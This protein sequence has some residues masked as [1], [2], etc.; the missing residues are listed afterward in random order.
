MLKTLVKTQKLMISEIVLEK[1][2]L[3]V[4]VPKTAARASLDEDITRQ[5][6]S[7]PDCISPIIM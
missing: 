2:F 1:D 6:M 3:L 4:A 7:W 5:D